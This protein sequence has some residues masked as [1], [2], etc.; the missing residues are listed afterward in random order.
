[1]Y[2]VIKIAKM[3]IIV[4]NSIALGSKNFNTLCG[5]KPTENIAIAS[6]LSERLDNEFITAPKKVRGSVENIISGSTYVYS[7]IKSLNSSVTLADSLEMFI[8]YIK[9]IIIKNGTNSVIKL[10]VKLL[11]RYD[12]N[13]A[14]H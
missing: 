7:I 13:L 8:T 12:F 6:L 2:G 14:I 3:V 4:V 9:D 5:L 11:S 10:L 1:V